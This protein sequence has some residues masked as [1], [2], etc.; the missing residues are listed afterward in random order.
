M[1]IELGIWQFVRIMVEAEENPNGNKLLEAYKETWQ[2][3]DSTLSELA[4]KDME[5]Y[6]AVMMENQIV[7]DD[8]SRE[9]ADTIM[10]MVS[11][12]IER[13]GALIDD[14]EDE[15]DLLLD[16]LAFEIQ[17]LEQLVDEIS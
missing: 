5:E 8:V 9:N 16:D 6:S 14:I 11:N 13:M 12:V 2:D 7:L 4:S 15:N 3:V 10:E 17:G 1:K